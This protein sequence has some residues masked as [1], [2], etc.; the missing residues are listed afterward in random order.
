MFDNNTVFSNLQL[1]EADSNSVW[2]TEVIALLKNCL[3]SA[4]R[5][6]LNGSP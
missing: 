4:V 3:V 6:P 2:L 1:A 5:L